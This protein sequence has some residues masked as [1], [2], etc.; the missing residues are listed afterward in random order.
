M[1]SFDTFSLLFI[2]FLALGVI[3]NILYAWGYM[4]HIKRKWHFLVHYVTFILSMVGVVLA[5]TPLAFLFSWELMSLTSWQLIL[6]NATA[7]KELQAAR[8]YF[9][10][11]HFGF[12]FILLFFLVVSDGQL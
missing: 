5:N 3:P 4:D 7:Q 2:L 8:F 10:M 9:F 12:I 1:F 6:N 11:T